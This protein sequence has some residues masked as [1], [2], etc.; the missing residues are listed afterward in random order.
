MVGVIR[1]SG[2][3]APQSGP[4]R[5]ALNLLQMEDVIEQV[6]D[7]RRL[8]AVALQINSPGGSPVQS[9]LLHDRIRALA[10]EKDV[11]VLAFCEDVAASGG[12]WLAC[13]GDEVYANEN[14]II[15][16]IGVISASFGFEAAIEKLGIE[17][18][19]HTSGEMK[20]FLDPFQPE[21][22]ADLDRLGDLQ[23]EIHDAFK[24]HVLSRREGKLPEATD[25][26]DKLF[27]GEFWRGGRALELGLIDQ[28][29]ESRQVLRER[30][31]DK[32]KIR[33][34]QSKKGW[35]QR[36]LNFGMDS[37]AL[38]DAGDQFLG[39]LNARAHWQRFGL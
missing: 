32:V 33:R 35:L 15:G 17:R 3:I 28:I 20:S 19:V 34:I 14:S 8:K 13:A 37:G 16:S 24:A 10:A 5:Q 9:A 30:F 38:A 12:Y 6:F 11:P 29:G 39:A 22:Q 27:S 21:R 36:R 4:G 31:G 7:L 23:I 25:A 2:I 26:R 1:L 18:R